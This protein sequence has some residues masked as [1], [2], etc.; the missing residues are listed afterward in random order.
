MKRV[1][2]ESL[3]WLC[4]S[5]GAGA[6]AWG[7]ASAIAALVAGAPSV[8]LPLLWMLA[9]GLIRGGAQSLARV[10]AA[11]AAQQQVAPMRTTLLRRFLGGT[12]PQPLSVGESAV[13]ALDYV[14]RVEGYGAQFLPIRFAAAMGPLLVAGLVALASPVSALILLATL[15]PFALGMVLAGTMAR[16]ASE[17]QLL[18][19]S[20]LSD[21]FS[22]RLRNLAMIRH[23]DAGDR[24]TRQVAE[25]TSAMAS[26]T[27]AVLRIAFLSSGVMEFF[28]ALSVAM[29]ALYCGFSLLGILPFP[30]PEVLTFQQA[31]FALALAPEFYLPMRRLA[32]AYHEKQLGEAAQGAIAPYLVEEAV[33]T[34]GDKHSSGIVLHGVECL[35]PG[36]SIGP[37]DFA[38][39][40]TGL[41]VITGPTGSG[42]TSLLAVIAGQLP[43]SSGRVLA[44]PPDSIAWAAQRPLILP[45][46]LRDNLTLGHP[47]ASDDDVRAVCSATGLD[48]LISERNKGLDVALDHRA[49]GLSGGELRRVGL[50]RAIVSNRPV[51]LCDEP[52]ADLDADSAAHIAQLLRNL[53]STHA[54]IVATHD[55]DL[56][57]L[58]DQVLAL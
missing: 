17:S 22:D 24:L 6:F 21:L 8:W 51:I 53:A 38:M 45:G 46:T 28:A 49:S 44:P 52:T 25:A 57:A 42:K 48:R 14:D 26:R 29:V 50:A 12:M 37:V 18:A 1:R 31:L 27:M 56:V 13:I 23:F 4:D 40:A 19:L 11:R 30:A 35:W 10:T 3:L 7:L 9:G 41:A 16:R 36:S 15:F 34:A 58:A 47:M 2:P 33:P 39:G 5:I 55:E 43:P 32:A 20:Q 54:V